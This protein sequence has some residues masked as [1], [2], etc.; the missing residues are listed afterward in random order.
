MSN[1]RK[2]KLNLIKIYNSCALK[3]SS[4]KV[5]TI[6]RMKEF[7]NHISDKVLICI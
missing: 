5:K 4:K 3:N 6:Y 7:T 1:K 2:N